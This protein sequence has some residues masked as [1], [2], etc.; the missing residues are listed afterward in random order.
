MRILTVF[1]DVHIYTYRY[2]F[3]DY[4]NTYFRFKIAQIIYDRTITTHTKRSVSS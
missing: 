4:Y 2:L 3:N 1:I